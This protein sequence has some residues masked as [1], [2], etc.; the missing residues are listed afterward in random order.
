LLSKKKYAAKAEKHLAAIL[1]D[2]AKANPDVLFNTL[3]FAFEADDAEGLAAGAANWSPKTKQL[4]LAAARHEAL[5]KLSAINAAVFQAKAEVVDGQKEK[6]VKIL[7]D[8]AD[9]IKDPRQG[10]FKVMLRNLA[11]QLGA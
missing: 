8:A 11:N 5:P 10:R 9:S 4:L 7:K 3:R 2:P 6:A 1:A